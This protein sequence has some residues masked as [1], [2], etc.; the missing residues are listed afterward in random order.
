[1]VVHR[2]PADGAGEIVPDPRRLLTGSVQMSMNWNAGK[3][4]RAAVAMA[5]VAG[6]TACNSSTT[7]PTPTLNLVETAQA[8]G[9][10]QTLLAAA[11]AAGLATEL[12]TGGPYTVFAPTDAAFAA[13]PAGTVE[14]LLNDIP[15]L[16]SILLYHVVQG[17]V[18]SMQA[19]G[20]SSATTLN[21]QSFP[22]TRQGT[23]LRVGSA[24]VI[25]ADIEATNG[26]IHVIDRVLIP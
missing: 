12:S 1:M 16:Q 8:A 6:M 20:L 10:F 13:L 25:Q 18:T 9:Q 4:V 23:S 11:T 5:A 3:S 17:R 15:T 24:T 22:I 14:A 21:G 7:E 2:R 19:A 26:I